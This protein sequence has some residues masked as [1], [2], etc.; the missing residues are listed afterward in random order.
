MLVC[1]PEGLKGDW[2]CWRD[3]SAAAL[4]WDYSSSQH[5]WK[6]ARRAVPWRDE[7]PV[8]THLNVM[9]GPGPY[10]S[11][12]TCIL[13][14]PILACWLFYAKPDAAFLRFRLASHRVEFHG[15]KLVSNSGNEGLGC[16]PNSIV[17]PKCQSRQS[18]AIR[19]VLMFLKWPTYATLSIR[20]LC[21]GQIV[22]EYLARARSVAAFTPM[23]VPRHLVPPYRHAPLPPPLTWA[24]RLI[25]SPPL[26]PLPAQAKPLSSLTLHFHPSSPPARSCA[27]DPLSPSFRSWPIGFSLF[28]VAKAV[29]RSSSVL[30][31]P[32][33][34]LVRVIASPAWPY[35]PIRSFP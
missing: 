16:C 5:D 21:R 19:R 27:V 25:S 33:S 15:V 32:L 26:I 13:P 3:A 1:G 23:Q 7:A 10:L 9:D 11:G 4:G 29:I 28:S 31:T 20:P 6:N 22:K 17:F 2:A 30:T 35:L 24:A 12:L 34:L 14:S 18:V 8:K